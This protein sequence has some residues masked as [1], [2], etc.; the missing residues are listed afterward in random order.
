MPKGTIRTM[1]LPRVSIGGLGGTIAM[2]SSAPGVLA[3]PELDVEQLVDALDDLSPVADIHG[4]TIATDPSPSLTLA[5]LGTALTWA[6]TEVDQG[7][8]G[9][10][11]MQGT[12]TLEESAFL[13]DLVWDRPE[14]FVLSGAMRTSS[15]PSPDGPA[16]LRAAII[17]AASEDARDCG[18]L[19]CLNDEV[20]LAAYVTKADSQSLESFVSPGAG[21]LGYVREGSFRRQWN[22]RRQAFATLSELP[23]EQTWAE[24]PTIEIPLI[25]AS[26]ADDGELIPVLVQ[27]GVDAI[28]VNGSGVGHVS[29]RMAAHIREAVREGVGVV[30]ASRTHQSGT[31]RSLY[32][33]AGS[34][35]DLAEAGATLAGRLSGRKARLAVRVLRDAGMS[36]TD[37]DQVFDQLWR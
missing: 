8:A 19:T 28:V 31:A 5:E 20:H 4:H 7:A 16:N 13:L 29:A 21:P 17:V 11:L 22:P 33:Y 12:D 23:P 25:E 10:V 24:R 1:S 35:S 34:E 26:L 27:A 32:G 14:P 30:V 36:F 3:T 9:I 6:R 2:T 18:V 37:I 15:Q